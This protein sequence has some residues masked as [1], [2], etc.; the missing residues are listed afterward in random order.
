ME[1]MLNLE[2]TVGNKERAKQTHNVEQS[3]GLLVISALESCAPSRDPH[4][5][6]EIDDPALAECMRVMR[7]VA[8]E[9]S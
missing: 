3:L 6:A 2:T 7:R 8:K 1:M 5:I 4:M 9:H